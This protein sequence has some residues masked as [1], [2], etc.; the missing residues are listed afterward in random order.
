[1]RGL[2]SCGLLIKFGHLE[3]QALRRRG[4]LLICVTDTSLH[5]RR[6]LIDKQVSR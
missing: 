2:S 6:T 3:A 5:A 1:V 4:S